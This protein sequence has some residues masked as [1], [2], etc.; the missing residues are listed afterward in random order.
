MARNEIK[1]GIIAAL[2][3][4]SSKVCCAIA[5]IDKNFNA[6]IIGFGHNLSK[7]IKNG[8]IVDMAEAKNAIARA[9][10]AAEY[11]AGLRVDSVFV[12]ISSSR[13]QS[14]IIKAEMSLSN[15]PIAENDIKKLVEKG[16]YRLDIG[17]SELLHCIPIGYSIDGEDAV[18]DPRG[19]Y[20]SSLGVNIH[21]ITHPSAPIKNLETV[22]ESCHLDI[23][24][25]IATPYASGLATLVD[26]EKELG[27]TIIDIGSGLTNI[28]VFNNGHIVHAGSIAVGGQNIT[29]DLAWGLTTSLSQAERL[30]T[31]Y[32]GAISSPKDNREMI[33]IFP[34]GE[35]DETLVKNLAKSEINNIIIPRIEET[36]ELVLLHLKENNLYDI[37]SHRVVLTGGCSLI[38]GIRE[39]ASYILNRQ[40]RIGN[41]I[42]IT[43]MPKNAKS[44]EF[45]T[46]IGL[47]NFAIKSNMI[48][49]EKPSVSFH[50]V[51]SPFEKLGQ[52]LFQSS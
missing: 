21:T 27:G 11:V 19:M 9:V 30:K 26:D 44:P 31:L 25:K 49:P 51:T 50:S 22:I 46:C 34:I 1:N 8:I 16:L 42:D 20:G 33:K 36:M 5:Q 23:A 15:K 52:W 6:K 24:M 7:G 29:Q 43:G 10:E 4:G 39:K 17:D 38:Q 48:K 12:N 45:A 28:A 41:V 2:D 37:P 14:S 40:V 13:L 32:G 3:I 35:E 47:L 18:A